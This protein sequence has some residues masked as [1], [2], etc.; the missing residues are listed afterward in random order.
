MIDRRSFMKAVGAVIAAPTAL[1]SLSQGPIIKN[2]NG[3]EFILSGKIPNKFD[4]LI[5][6]NERTKQSSLLIEF[7]D[8]FIPT[9]E[10]G[11]SSSKR[12]KKGYAWVVNGHYYLDY[13]DGYFYVSK[14]HGFRAYN[15]KE[16]VGGNKVVAAVNKPK[17]DYN[18]ILGTYDSI[19][20]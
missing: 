8:D 15:K 16:R 13:E 19:I 20:A 2:V 18:R 14:V 10:T 11:D 9:S 6:G 4:Y 1:S 7:K 5:L 17:G 3:M 12:T